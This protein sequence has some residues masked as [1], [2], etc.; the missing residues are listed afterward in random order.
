[1]RTMIRGFHQD[2]AS[3]W[4][5]ELSCGHTQHMRHRPPWE[6]RAW[7]LDDAERASRIGAE[8]ECPL[9]DMPAL[10]ANAREYKRTATFTEQTVPK[11]LLADHRT[12]EGTWAR[13]VVTS[14][15]LGYSFGDP[16]RSFVLTPKRSG[17]VLPQVAHQVELRGPVEF[18]VEFLQLDS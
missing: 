13:I 8:I 2:T 5:A 18:H 6:N 1:M 7:V 11:G 14:G 16:R 12:R 10:P 3:D 15:E 4:V 9:C 17:I